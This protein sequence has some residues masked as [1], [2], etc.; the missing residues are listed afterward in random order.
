VCPLL[1]LLLLLFVRCAC[2]GTQCPGCAY[3][4]P[5]LSS[6]LRDALLH[7]LPAA[8]CTNMSYYGHGHVHGGLCVRVPSDSVSEG[9]VLLCPVCCGGLLSLQGCCPY[10]RLAKA[11]GAH[12]GHKHAGVARHLR[13]ADINICSTKQQ[14]QQRSA[15]GHRRM[16]LISTEQQQQ[17]S[18]KSRT[19]H[20]LLPTAWFPHPARPCR[21]ALETQM[22][23]S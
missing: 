7:T 2:A 18:S 20:S 4:P 15:A 23:S 21:K 5:P 17:Q 14:H 19:Q 1:L 10:R 22:G 8:L 6:C 13:A 12:E 3:E 16:C 11:P 9:F